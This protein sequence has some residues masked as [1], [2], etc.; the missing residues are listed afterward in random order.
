MKSSNHQI[1][2]ALY[3]HDTLGLG[4]IRRNLA[5]AASLVGW[6]QSIAVL[7]ISGTQFAPKL[8]PPTG[9]DFLTLPAIG[10]NTEDEYAAQHLPIHL[11]ELLHLRSQIISSALSTF[12]PD[13]LI[14]DKVPGGLL[15]ELLPTLKTLRQSGATRCVLGL[16]DILD[17]PQTATREWRNSHSAQIVK[18]FYD[19]VWIYG[20]PAIY[21][22]MH[23][24]AF[25][26]HCAGKAH[27][28]GYVCRSM[29]SNAG[30]SLR[31]DILTELDLDTDRVALCMVGG[32]QDGFLLAK[33][34]VQAELPRD[35]GAIVLTGPFMDE[36]ERRWLLELSRQRARTRIL[37][38]TSTPE[39]LLAGADWVVS[40]AGY[41]TTCEILAA[42]KRALLVPR[43]K[44]R[45]EQW[46]RAD[47]LAQ[48]GS[49]SVLHPDSLSPTHISEWLHRTAS[50]P[51]PLHSID[52]HGLKRIPDLVNQL[53][54]A[55][56][57]IRRHKSQ[58]AN[59]RLIGA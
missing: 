30:D 40:M 46:I 15:G 12:R 27:F 3:S 28:T 57:P 54:S 42:N 10:K 20:D 18:Q 35:S 59:H 31:R 32:G 21:N 41:N 58:P 39:Q 38:F 23:E 43:V 29:P 47:R 55:P 11:H 53:I 49:I 6:N 2:I 19:A 17:D 45:L 1:R 34:F 13:I 37:S 56:K 9:V 44:P 51:A 14:A 36:S 4:H 48:N 22:P 26:R 5:I 16:R 52:L 24:Y 8:A 7:L 50:A 33:T 25:L